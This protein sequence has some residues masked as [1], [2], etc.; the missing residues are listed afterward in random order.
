MEDFK[1]EIP[2]DMKGNGGSNKELSELNKN[3]KKLDKTMYLNLDVI[4]MLSSLLGDIYKL[5]Q[6]LIKILSL[7]FMMAFIPLMPIIKMLVEN[8]AEFTKWVMPG[9][10]GL[11]GVFD[12]VATVLGKIIDFVADAMIW[13]IESL[14]K[15]IMFLFNIGVKIG[16]FLIWIVEF[17]FNVGVVIGE[18]IIKVAE[19]LAWTLEKL[20]EGLVWVWESLLLP[21]FKVLWEGIK[22]VWEVLKGAFQLIWE[23]ITWVWNT[24]Y[25][26]V[27]S[28]LA[29]MFK[30]IWTVIIEPVWNWIKDKF[31]LMK[32]VLGNIVDAIKGV[33]NKIRNLISNLNP[34]KSSKSTKV[35]DAIIRPDGQIIQ[36]DPK[37]YIFATKTPEKMFGQNQVTLN[38]NNP[39]VREERDIRKIAEEV[40][41]VLERKLCRSY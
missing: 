6:P 15:G 38:I 4:E 29:E 5:V 37:D 24:L 41:K 22:W 1:V 11:Q 9:M 8:L 33:A 21:V 39:V 25:K 27:F 20:A 12:K 34:F 7:L 28:W 30:S 18:L 17:L 16:E 13:S 40:S 3:V 36:T 10:K 31:N 26:P 35:N 19:F 14:V 32:D 2:F 23:G